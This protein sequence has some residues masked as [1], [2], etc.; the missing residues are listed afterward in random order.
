MLLP[1]LLGLLLFYGLPAVRAVQISF[2]DWSLLRPARDVG[3]ANYQRL[4]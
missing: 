2:T 1:A 4:L 3:W